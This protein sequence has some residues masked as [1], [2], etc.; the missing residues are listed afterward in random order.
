MR[1]S[2]R[3]EAGTDVSGVSRRQFLKGGGILAGAALFVGS[4]L[5]GCATDAEQPATEP[6]TGAGSTTAAGAGGTTIGYSVYDTDILIIGTGF[7]GM[8]A[9]F[10]AN[11]KGSRVLLVDKGPFEF[12]GATGMNW[13][14]EVTWPDAAPSSYEQASFNDILANQKLVKNVW[15]M[16]GSDADAW[17]AA[18]WWVKMGNTTWNRLPDGSF[19]NLI[20]AGMGVNLVQ[21]GFSRHIQDTLKTQPVTVIDNTMITDLFLDNGVCVGAIGYH[22]L[23]GEYRVIRAK[24]TIATTG[25]C[26]QMYGW[27]DVHPISMNTPDNTSDVDAA[28]YRHGVSLVSNEF[29]GVDLIS[30][31]PSSLGASFNAGIGA[32][33]N[34]MIYVCDKDGDFFMRETDE[35][36]VSRP[37]RDRIL[38][39]KGGDHGGVFIDLT[40]PESQNPQNLRPCYLRNVTLWKERFDIDVTAA[41]YRIPVALEAFEHGGSFV[42]DENCASSI[43]GLYGTR[44]YGLVKGHITQQT[45]VG[46]YA[47]MKAIE[48]AQSV[49]L[50]KVDWSAAEAEIGRIDEIR[51]REIGGGIRPFEIRHKLQAA[52]YQNWEPATDAGKLQAAI[53]EIERIKNDDLPKQVVADKSVTFNRDW[54]E[55]IENYNLIDMTEA[56]LRAALMREE[57]RL[58]FYRTDFPDADD[59][60]WHVNIYCTLKDGSMELSKSEQVT[61]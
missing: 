18:L 46:V 61:V 38:N 23:T 11:A 10:E 8:A 3:Y 14:Q 20:A 53:D 47:A 17:N 1:E 7:G 13:D 4:G 24:A 56:S 22:V 19:E 58:T 50:D 44:G 60:N 35:Y 21:R 37:I 49:S 39:G 34:H 48:Y 15:E 25:A 51:T 59:E 41:G 27:L 31:D 32:D 12:S 54:K 26:C 33:G 16:V 5:A 30:V 6:A 2:D 57:S 52:F 9:A 55:A 45:F 43:P 28:A 42:I 29:F 36:D 40:N